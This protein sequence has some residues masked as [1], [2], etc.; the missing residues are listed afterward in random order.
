MHQLMI[1]LCLV[2]VVFAP[3][4]LSA[5]DGAGGL[6]VEQF[7]NEVRVLGHDELDMVV[8]GQAIVILAFGLSGGI[9]L[10]ADGHATPRDGTEIAT[11]ASEGGANE[12]EIDLPALQAVPENPSRDHGPPSSPRP[13][14]AAPQITFTG[15]K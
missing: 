12:I 9:N 4:A 6:L 15:L 10:F 1:G 5:Q 8:A 13:V 14:G 3:A 7:Q 2:S 11:F